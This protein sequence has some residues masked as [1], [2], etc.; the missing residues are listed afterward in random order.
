MR[1]ILPILLLALVAACSKDKDPDRP[2]KLVA[3]PETLKIHKAWS[4]KVGG[5]KVPLRL[6]LSL[7]VEGD[8]VYA[9]GEKGEVAAFNLSN[10]H[11]EW[12]TRTK[13]PLG[14][15]VGFGDGKIV[16]GST[17][18]DVIALDAR[19][20]KQLWT[21]N[22][23][24]EILAAPAVSPKLTLVRGVDGKLH[25]LSMADGH[26]LWQ[27]QQSVPKLSLRGTASPVIV[28]DVAVTGFDNGRL[29]AS[30]L[31]DG[32][33][34]WETQLQIPTGK[35]DLDRLVDIDTRAQIAGNDIYVVG[36]QGKLAMVA[37]DSGQIWWSHEMSSYRGLAL[38]EN[39]IYMSTSIGEVVALTRRNGTEVWRQKALAHRGLSGPAVAGDAI[40]VADYK[41]Y[42]H[43]LNKTTGALMGRV[44]AGKVRY[45][46]PPVYADGTLLLL[47]DHGVIDAYRAAPLAT[48]ATAAALPA[49]AHNGHSGG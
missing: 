45:T 37:L 25:A 16:V 31:N 41:G 29:V 38:D 39:N 35:T 6:G 26:E 44:R 13:L 24:T 10:G 19:T 42:V 36:F 47:N 8:T 32:S 21:T 46:N 22:I 43:W 28:G 9:A 17:D 11:R 34:V 33:S 40:V 3:F 14:G 48:H 1:R 18:G 4:E 20:G 15:A 49:P 12:Q 7:D 30:S 27:Q 23:V 2:T 5:T